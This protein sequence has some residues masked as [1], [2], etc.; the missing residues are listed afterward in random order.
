MKTEA[1]R[2]VALAE[3]IKLAKDAVALDVTDGHSWCILGTLI[4]AHVQ[5]L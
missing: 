3:S 4:T 5:E 1:E 2:R